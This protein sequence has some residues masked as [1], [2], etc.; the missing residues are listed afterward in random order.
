M[1]TQP[2]NPLDTTS[3]DSHPVHSY[4]THPAGAT[5][6]TS[7]SPTTAS[8][9]ELIASLTPPSPDQITPNIRAA[10]VG[11]TSTEDSQDPTLSIP[12]QLS[13]CGAKLAGLPVKV[14]IVAHYW[15]I[16]TGRLDLDA[17]GHSAAHTRF[18]VPVPR[19]GGI[20]DLLA[21]AAG[22]DRG[23]DVVIAEQVSRTARD[24]RA[25][26]EFEHRLRQN[27]IQLWCANEP[28]DLGGGDPAATTMLLRGMNRAIADWYVRNLLEQSRAGVEQ[29]IKAGYNIG[30]IPHGYSA[31]R[32]PHPVPAKRARGQAK[33]TLVINEDTAPTIRQIFTWRLTEQL[34][35]SRIC[36]RLNQDL[37]AHPSPTGGPWSVSTVSHILHNPKYTGYQ[38]YNRTRNK[39]SLHRSR[40][41][42]VAEW[43]WSPR[44]AH[45]AI[46][47]IDDF[48]A[49]QSIGSTH[50]RSR[51]D[52][53]PGAPNPH[54]RTRR[55]YKLRSYITCTHCGHRMCGKTDGG[56]RTYYFCQ[57][58]TKAPR[59]ENQPSSIYLPEPEILAGI[60]TFFNTHV[61]GPDRRELFLATI[62]TTDTAQAEQHQ[63]EINATQQ[64]I[65]RIETTRDRLLRNLGVFDYD[66]DKPTIEHI[67]N[68]LRDLDIQHHTTTADLT[69]LLK[70]QS[71]Q[72]T[73]DIDLLDQLPT[74]HINLTELPTALLRQLLD[75]FHFTT[76]YDHIDHHAHFT[77]TITNATIEHINHLTNHTPST[78]KPPLPVETLETPNFRSV[79]TT[80]RNQEMSTGIPA[81]HRCTASW[82]RLTTPSIRRWHTP[83]P[84]GPDQS[85]A[86]GTGKNHTSRRRSQRVAVPATA[87]GGSTR[88]HGQQRSSNS[89]WS[90]WPDPSL[91]TQTHRT[92]LC[93]V[94]LAWG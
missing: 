63:A 12:R 36:D 91:T 81:A 93:R 58:R 1:D 72:P 75:A 89:V 53:I 73:H 70:Q 65:R 9:E 29:H 84:R 57:P 85:L 64:A 10:F 56:D 3:T 62:D 54:P 39:T 77:I 2:N 21:A 33:T 7:E 30:K 51:R 13:T 88:S 49:A 86:L 26:T 44:P 14:V 67:R 35:Y 60:T 8:V 83:N 69:E 48:T 24:T 19:D 6:Q 76:T 80:G 82:V 16:E 66:T 46:I 74:T 27:D 71:P 15:D 18:D 43:I 28:I 59:P 52:R 25:S 90:L 38:V 79:T 37:G 61:F 87:L 23:F 45:P 17:R 5:A 20:A 55:V 68:Q 40:T 50:E 32:I 47:S 92:A 31:N 42:P 22:K 34:G 11:R 41:K 4:D 94:W 78:A